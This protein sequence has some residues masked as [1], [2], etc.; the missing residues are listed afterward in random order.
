MSYS[1]KRSWR[2]FVFV[3]PFLLFVGLAW[4]AASVPAQGQITLVGSVDTPGEGWGIHV[5]G[6]YAYVADGY[7]MLTVVDVHNPSNPYV[8]G[9]FSD[10]AGRAFG[11]YTDG[12]YA[13][14]ANKWDR[15]RILDVSDP[16]HP[17]P[18]G[19]WKEKDA[20]GNDTG[21]SKGVWKVGHY[22]ILTD[23]QGGLISIDVADPAHPVR[24][25]QYLLDGLFGETLWVDGTV[26]YVTGGQG[27]LHI[28][29]VSDPTNLRKLSHLPLTGY[30]YASQA[31][32]GL[33]FVAGWGDGGHI[34]DVS[35]PTA[36]VEVGTWPSANESWHAFGVSHFL[37]VADGTAG[38][39]VFDIADPAHPQFVASGATP[40]RALY[41]DVQ[42]PYAY[43]SYG[44][45]DE[46]SASGPGGVAIFDLSLLAST[47][48]PTP[49]PTI[50]PTPTPSCAL[51]GDL[52][53]DGRVD[54]ADVNLIAQQW[55]DSPPADPRFDT[56]PNGRV[57]LY[58]VM[59]VATRFGTACPTPTPI[60]T[61]T[62]TPTPTPTVTP[63][64]GGTRLSL[65]GMQSYWG[66][67][68]FHLRHA[69]GT[70]TP[71][72]AYALAQAGKYDFLA[73][74]EQ[75]DHLTTTL[76]DEMGTAAQA[77]NVEGQ[78]IALRN[79]EQIGNY[80]EGHIL[81]F[82]TD[83]Y[84]QPEPLADF[85]PWLAAQPSSVFAMFQ[86]PR[87]DLNWTFDDFA[88]DPAAD[89]HITLQQ[90]LDYYPG[91]YTHA[92]DFGWHVGGTG[93]GDPYNTALLGHNRRYGVML[94][95]LT[96]ANLL[97]ALQ[98]GRVFG[99]EHEGKL[100]IA[101]QANGVWMGGSL[102]ATGT[103]DF[104]IQA[105]DFG[106][107]P[108]ASV[109]LVAGGAC[110]P[111][112]V[113]STSP[114]AS[115]VTWTPSLARY[116]SYYF[117]EATL[118]DGRHARSAPIWATR[119]GIPQGTPVTIMPVADATISAWNPTTN[120]AGTGTLDVRSGPVQS[121]LLRFDLSAMPPGTPVHQ[122]LLRVGTHY[123]SNDRDLYVT[124]YPLLRSWA[125]NQVTWQQAADGVSW[126][127]PGAQ[128]PAD[129][130]DMPADVVRTKQVMTYTFDLTDLAQQWVDHPDQ[131]FGLLLEG[132]SNSSVEH[133]FASQ[134]N[135]AADKRPRLELWVR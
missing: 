55:G 131:N 9:T 36:P 123:R 129:R 101:L 27:G 104:V 117:A 121:A 62:P 106:G 56:V 79:F 75:N 130:D 65:D 115:Q 135:G 66:D 125:A 89:R 1:P 45:T 96:T 107:Q 102:P 82:N 111:Q 84:V 30:A 16:A 86:H 99:T 77:A 87:P 64:G 28:I 67:L 76:W 47:P 20:Q 112:T 72:E 11:V 83:S 61:D 49:S 126:S 58:D 74:T 5:S 73:V 69:F 57:D 12:T 92:L 18:A 124:A 33:A 23:E 14:L 8:A 41:I 51:P 63:T 38:L 29:D 127:V 85:Y 34:I 98:A 80:Q 94:P 21:N 122:A 24:V 105:R 91:E 133:Q 132:C 25:D 46:P 114:Q 48:T 50:T 81:V 10:Y 100:A 44:P 26:A 13:Y 17:T 39:R 54:I 71:A 70:G 88:Y 42:W 31:A 134:E 78:F 97:S 118:A 120:F 43:V 3:L 103:L 53:G 40:N 93:F 109:D 113:A 59:W 6:G 4:R 95:S 32:N 22:A 68:N 108:I 128:G 2:L 90:V 110:G 119:Q 15:L 35:D 37:L 7:S 60:P 19:G 116:A 52:S